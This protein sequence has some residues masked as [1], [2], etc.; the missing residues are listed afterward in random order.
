MARQASRS[1]PLK[2]V[3]T[4][5]KRRAT[6]IAIVEYISLALTL[7]L[8]YICVCMG[9]GFIFPFIYIKEWIMGGVI[10][11]FFTV[12]LVSFV[13]KPNWDY[14]AKSLDG[15]GLEERVMTALELEDNRDVYANM[16]RIDTLH[17]LENTSPSV[18]KF[19]IP[20]TRIQAIIALLIIIIIFLVLPNP[21]WDFVKD[22][23][24]MRESIEKAARE[25]EKEGKEKVDKADELSE[26]DKEE[27]KKIISTLANELGQSKDYK[28]ALAKISKAQDAVDRYM[29]KK[30]DSLSNILEN[31]D[32]TSSLGAAIGA[33]NSRAVEEE[34]DKLKRKIQDTSKGDNTVE[35]LNNAFKAAAEEVV[36]EKLKEAFN[37]MVGKLSDFK[38]D[39][40]T[41]NDVLDG[42]EKLQE[43]IVSSM[44]Q[45]GMGDPGD[46]KYLL[47]NMKNA[48]IGSADALASHGGYGVGKTPEGQTGQGDGIGQGTG[49]DQSGGTGQG[50][51]TGQSG[52]MGQGTGTGQSG[53][54]GQG[55]GIGKT[56]HSSEVGE[57][58]RLGGEAEVIENI[59]GN[60][61]GS[62]NI[63]SI[64]IEGGIGGKVGPVPYKKVIG[65]YKRQAM[66]AIDRKT[67]PQGLENIVKDYF[68]G[69]EE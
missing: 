50:T 56:G 29:E 58:H 35:D 31:Q 34:M 4:P 38:Y 59:Q 18:M 64:E 14:V 3:L 54:M 42:L 30:S 60:P 57:S 15:Y 24:N 22:Y 65:T 20:K 12:V 68:D 47:Q 1:S 61:T 46:I 21:K 19:N 67:L 8:A 23:W 45:R 7:I 62:G 28:E 53:G 27:I 44:S 40:E 49:T 41:V 69:L 5:F 16:Q 48:M 26:E 10:A 32:A 63:D 17:Y 66:E 13:K 51:G 11:I 9:V 36:D 37:N 43:E 6:V 2:R 33:N 25:I 39:E 52:G 55:D